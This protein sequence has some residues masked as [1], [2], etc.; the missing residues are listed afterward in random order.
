[1]NNS[2]P[3]SLPPGFISRRHRGFDDGASDISVASSNMDYSGTNCYYIWIFYGKVVLMMDNN[4]WDLFG[5]RPSSIQ[6]TDG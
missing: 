2:G 1:M 3:E 5:N 6:A 4:G